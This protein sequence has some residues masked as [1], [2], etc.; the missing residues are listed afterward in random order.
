MEILDV[1]S[2]ML[3]SLAGEGESGEYTCEACGRM[4]QI[5]PIIPP[6]ICRNSTI[7][8]FITGITLEYNSSSNSYEHSLVLYSI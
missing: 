6:L 1:L 8:L 2:P 4:L 3:P 7:I 5:G